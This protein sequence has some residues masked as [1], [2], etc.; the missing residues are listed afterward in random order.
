MQTEGDEDDAAGGSSSIIQAAPE[1]GRAP[2]MLTNPVMPS[3]AE[4]DAH[5]ACHWPFRNWCRACVEGRGRDS[6]HRRSKEK[7]EDQLVPT[8]VADYCYM[9]REARSTAE[10]KGLRP[11]LVVREVLSGNTLAMAVPQKGAEVQ[12]VVQ[13]CAKWIDDMGHPKVR[14]KSDQESSIVAWWNAVAKMRGDQTQTVPE[15]SPV[16]DSQSNGAAEQAVGEVK[17]MIRTLKAALDAKL[18]AILE[19]GHPIFA[20]MVEYA[21]VLISRHKVNEDGRT[22]FETIKNKKAALPICAFGEKVMYLPSKSAA[23]RRWQYGAYLGIISRTN[24]FVVSTET[25]E[26]IK[27]RTIRRVAE[28]FRWDKALIDK[29]KCT[30][31]APVDGHQA[32]DIPI[33]IPLDGPKTGMPD[34]TPRPPQIRRLRIP[35]QIYLQH[36]DEGCRGCRA[37]RQGGPQ[38]AHSA[39]CQAKVQEV[40]QS[41]P[42]WQD[43]ID[44]N[45]LRTN[46]RLAEKLAKDDEKEA[47]KARVEGPPGSQ[48]PQTPQTASSSGLTETE[49]AAIPTPTPAG[50]AVPMEGTESTPPPQAPADEIDGQHPA[51]KL[52][53]NAVMDDGEMQTDGGPRAR[54]R[55]D[56]SEIYS[57]PRIAPVAEEFGLRP[58][59]S[60]DLTT[61]NPKGQRWDFSK[62]EMRKQAREL[63]IKTRPTVLIGSPPCTPYSQLQKLNEHRR[64]PEVVAREK[65]AADVHMRFCCELY[66]EQHRRGA[67]FLHEH[68]AGAESWKM[69]CMLKVMAMKGVEA[70]VAD[71]CCFGLTSV[72]KDGPGLVKKPTRFVTNCIRIRKALD[73]RCGGGHRHVHLMSGRAAKAAFYPP[74]LC[75]TVVRAVAE[76]VREHKQKCIDNLDD[77][78]R[79]INRVE[80]NTE[81]MQE[82]DLTARE[83]CTLTHGGDQCWDDVKGGWIDPN[84]VARARQ[85]EMAFVRKT[86]VYKKVDRRVAN[87]KGCKIIKVR[88]VDTNKGTEECPNVRSRLVAQEFKG[89]G[90]GISDFE[91][92]SAMPPLEAMKM[93]VSHAATKEKGQRRQLMVV[94]IRRA[95]FNAPARR[96]VFVEI[97]PEDWEPGDEGRCAELLAS[98]YGTRDAARNW[99]EELQHFFASIG[100]KIGKASPCTYL[101]RRAGRTTRA[102]VHGDDIVCAGTPEDL[103]WLR[104][105]IEKRFE[106]KTQLLGH[107][108]GESTEVKLLNRSIRLTRDGLEIEADKRHAEA[109]IEQMGVKK[110]KSVTTPVDTG[111]KEEGSIEEALGVE[112]ARI[113]RGLAARLNYLAQDRPDLKFAALKASKR[114]STPTERDWEI[115][116]RVARYLIHRPRAATRGRMLKT[117]TSEFAPTLTGQATARRGSR[118]QEE[119]YG[120]DVTS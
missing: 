41:R 116:K 39:A 82:K 21:G 117:A 45:E 71:Q 57:R 18:G 111:K 120:M 28:E 76:Q 15:N 78:M 115:L 107:G 85:E 80:K 63:L 110:G 74:E 12:W 52:R 4:V 54:I 68:P 96:P 66:E 37:L 3:K 102:A 114:M 113:F 109:I 49:R 62:V 23:V 32:R 30:P 33:E 29:M 48:E 47:K 77:G 27:V 93:V 53:V 83:I 31:W 22:G 73:R 64:D 10:Q 6:A 72:D 112:D 99:A 87:E 100:G 89:K 84:L 58:G 90:G 119:R 104:M 43:K 42:E 20:F 91:L 70:V 98:L 1:E 38:T 101:L 35:R 60:L 17:G 14:N 95:Y 105:E 13:R 61:A 65:V 94:D 8:V 88:W 79:D 86:P 36:G 34:I 2:K 75:R 19:P 46:E 5:E 55:P 56:V 59:W 44:Q 25:G 40:V 108:P 24:E 97:P 81:S 118:Y 7:K 92:Y 9:S 69:R 11:I 50:E 106:T 103:R 51:K 67:F 16:G 26:A